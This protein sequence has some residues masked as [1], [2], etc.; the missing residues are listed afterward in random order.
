MRSLPNDGSRTLFFMTAGG[1]RRH[2]PT[3]FLPDQVPDFEGE[4]AVFEVDKHRGVWTFVRQAA[5]D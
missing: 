4:E 2:R 1:D 5:S 3:F